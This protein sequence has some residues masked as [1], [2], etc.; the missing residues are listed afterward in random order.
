MARHTFDIPDGPK[1][2]GEPQTSV[3]LVELTGVQ[4]ANCLENAEKAV[5]VP[6]G[7]DEKGNVIT[8][9]KLIPSPAKMSML[10][11]RERIESIGELP[12]PISDSV[13]EKLSPDD[14]NTLLAESDKFDD[15]L[16][17]VAQQGEP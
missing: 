3:T 2:D 13:W 8:D 5:Q 12:T 17:E 6:V 4:Y 15:A 1:L 14:I 11:L 16:A 10:V 9:F 7:V